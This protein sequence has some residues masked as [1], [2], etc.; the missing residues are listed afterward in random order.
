VLI[1]GYRSPL[2][3]GQKASPFLVL[4]QEQLGESERGTEYAVTVF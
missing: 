2:P 1:C 3:K 4:P